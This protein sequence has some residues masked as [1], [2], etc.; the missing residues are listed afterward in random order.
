MGAIAQILGLIVTFVMVMEALRRFGIDVGWL[1]P[2]TFFRRRSWRSKV[3]EPPLYTLEH[4]IDVV[5]VL[6]LAAVQTTGAISTEQKL[7]VQKL[8]REHLSMDESESLSL[9]IASSHL[10]RHR[11]LE[12]SEVP[13]VLRKSADK[14]TE[15]HLQTL[16]TVMRAAAQIESPINAEQQQL[17][18]AV[19]QFFERRKAAGKTWSA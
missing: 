15:Y 2:L 16:N 3:T 7:G 1:N 13:T 6:A 5:G 9:W 12:L 14:F 17:I 8:L 10:L 19:G 18:D 4:P 11:A